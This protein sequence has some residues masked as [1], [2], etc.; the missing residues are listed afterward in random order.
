[1]TTVD[2]AHDIYF[3][4]SN[5]LYGV[6]DRQDPSSGGV[7]QMEAFLEI[8]IPSVAPTVSTPIVISTS[9]SNG[10][11]AEGYTDKK[12]VVVS[13]DGIMYCYDIP[14]GNL[15]WE[16]NLNGQVRG[17][18]SFRTFRDQNT[19]NTYLYVGT[20]EGIFYCID[21]LN[22]S[23]VWAHEHPG[24][25]GFVSSTTNNRT[26]ITSACTSDGDIYTFDADGGL[27]WRAENLGL[28]M[29]AKPTL[30]MQSLNGG[31]DQILTS[32]MGSTMDGTLFNLDGATGNVLWSQNIDGSPIVAPPYMVSTFGTIPP[33]SFYVNTLRGKVHNVSIQDGSVLGSVGLDAS[34]SSS[35]TKLAGDELRSQNDFLYVSTEKTLYA[36]NMIQGGEEAWSLPLDPP[37]YATPNIVPSANNG[38]GMRCYINSISGLYGINAET[39]V[40]FSEYELPG[41]TAMETEN[42]NYQISPVVIYV[43]PDTGVTEVYHPN[44]IM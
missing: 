2:N 19:L 31:R 37:V 38:T 23:L 24:R 32:V 7:G 15:L 3:I 13:G 17:T 28:L 33:D 14:S 11:E 26:G 20:T 18:P 25:G 42:L 41:F 9:A 16:L 30:N 39:G 10:T 44:N 43:E 8:A 22:E 1:M 6:R 34:I 12:L 35:P 4:D 27:L 5:T 36:L 21:V 29:L 40:I